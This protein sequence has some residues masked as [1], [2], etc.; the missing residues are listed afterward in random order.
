MSEIGSLVITNFLLI[1]SGPHG[2]LCGG[3][4]TWPASSRPALLT[5][6]KAWWSVIFCLIMCLDTV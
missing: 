3:N 6:P 5:M 4:D 1:V 2:A